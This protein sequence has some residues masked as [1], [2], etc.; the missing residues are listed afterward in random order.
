MIDPKAVIDPSAKLHE[1]VTIGP[2]SVIGEKVRIGAK[3]WIGPHVVIQGPTSIGEGNKIYQFSSIGDIPQDKKY[4]GEE[5]LLEI[6][7]GNIIREYTTINR[8]TVQGGGVTRIGNN[9]WIMAYTHIAHDCLIG[10]YTTFANNASLAGHVIVEDYATLGGY[11]LV[12][13]FCS[14]GTYSFCS[15]ASVVHKDVPPYVLV[16]GHMAKPVGINLIGLRRAAFQ[17]DTI[18]NLRNAY[19]LL[20]RQGLRF[21]DSIQEIK[22]LAEQS[23]EV[24]IFLD[25]LIKPYRSIIR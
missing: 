12:S 3:T 23:L 16:A 18:R 13:Q 9:N 5:T 21:E 22:Q 17:E 10:N 15:I 2:Y 14:I 7:N 8:G 11:A 1:T 19:R 25:F 24:Q 20:Y 6:G 4:H